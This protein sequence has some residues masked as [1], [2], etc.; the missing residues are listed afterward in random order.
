[1][2][3]TRAEVEEVF[4]NVMSDH[5]LPCRLIMFDTDLEYNNALGR[6]P[7]AP[8][9]F[10]GNAIY[11]VLDAISTHDVLVFLIAHEIGHQLF[12]PSSM[13]A[14]MG[15]QAIAD[16]NKE[17]ITNVIHYQNVFADAVVN[18]VNLEDKS[19][20]Q[21]YPGVIW[22]AVEKCY[23]VDAAYRSQLL[24]NPATSVQ[25]GLI[26]ALMGVE[27]FKMN[28]HTNYDRIKA[29]LL[30]A[31]ADLAKMFTAL[32]TLISEKDLPVRDIQKYYE[33]AYPLLIATRNLMDGGYDGGGVHSL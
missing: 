18:S 3:V 14:V 11:V 19:Y 9:Y 33:V 28:D 5:P 29:A 7:I 13:F 21:R 1:M 26:N 10:T 24:A 30:H 25:A 12:D 4:N 6:K 2:T 8:A 20:N 27:W 31:S 16:H 22:R 15:L 23:Q 17:N 32:E